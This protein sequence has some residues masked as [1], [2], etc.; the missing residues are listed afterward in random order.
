MKVYLTST[1]KCWCR[2]LLPSSEWLNLGIT[3]VMISF[4]FRVHAASPRTHPRGIYFLECESCS[5]GASSACGGRG[6]A[7]PCG[8]RAPRRW[9]AAAGAAQH[10]VSVPTGHVTHG[11]RG[12]RECG[13]CQENLKQ[14]VFCPRVLKLKFASPSTLMPRQRSALAGQPSAQIKTT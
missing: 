2:I 6:R 5:R 3:E 13:P 14:H 9:S 11:P 7:P 12:D 1:C 4:H 10:D 8:C